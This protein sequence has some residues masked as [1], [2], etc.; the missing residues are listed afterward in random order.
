MNE[1]IFEKVLREMRISKVLP[2]IKQYNNCQLLDVVTMLAV[3][4]HLE[5]PIEILNEI[6][7]VLKKMEL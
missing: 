2:E 1:P 4:E 6:N 7:R 3:L 5:Y